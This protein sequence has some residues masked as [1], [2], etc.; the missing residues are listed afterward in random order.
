MATDYEKNILKK[1]IHGGYVETEEDK[2]IIEE[3]AS[4]GFVS[5]GYDWDEGKPTAKLTEL[6]RGCLG[7]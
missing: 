7:I 2:K 6:G 1:F 3:F 4:I 5:C